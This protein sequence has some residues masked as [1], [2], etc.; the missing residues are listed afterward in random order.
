MTLEEM[1]Q[2]LQERLEKDNWKP[3]ELVTDVKAAAIF[4]ETESGNVGVAFH[5]DISVD[6][7][8]YVGVALLRIGARVLDSVHPY[9]VITD[10]E[11]IIPEGG[12][13]EEGY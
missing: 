1:V 10:E 3:G 5:S 9:E 6:D 12:D 7:A 13:D 8:Y 4:Y 2:Q 11:K